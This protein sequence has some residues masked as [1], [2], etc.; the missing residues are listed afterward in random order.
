MNHR[1]IPVLG[2]LVLR[3]LRT[4]V[5]TPALLPTGAAF[6]TIIGWWL[7]W[8]F[9][10]FSPQ[11][12]LPFST[13]LLLGASALWGTCAGTVVQ[14][15][16]G[17]CYAT[18]VRTGVAPR[19]IALAKLVASLVMTAA[20]SCAS[21]LS[22]G[23]GVA[24]S[25]EIALFATA[26]AVPV[27]LIETAISLAVKTTGQNS[28]TIIALL[29]IMLLVPL[30]Y[31]WPPLTP[32]AWASPLGPMQTA[33]AHMACGA[34]LPAGITALA[35]AW[36]GWLVLGGGALAWSMCRFARDIQKQTR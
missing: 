13:S 23:S 12:T 9:A 26:G 10:E 20:L 31:Q 2:A 8:S 22:L 5:R 35:L 14:E 7:T 24:T 1:R 6:I 16:T 25:T 21:C 15:R 4:I 32:Y 33:A 28:L 30:A 34:P 18:L 27:I 19:D 17:G 36:L 29:P 11:E 3:D